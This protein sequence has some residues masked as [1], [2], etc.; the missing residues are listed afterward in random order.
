MKS[1]GDYAFYN[2][3]H[4]IEVKNLSTLG[5]TA[6]SSS[7]G[8]VGYYANRVYKEGASYLSTIDNGYIIYDDG[9]DKILVS[10]TGTETDLTLLSGI[11]QIYKYAFYNCSNLTSVTIGNKVTS[12]GSYAFYNCSKLPNVTIP[13]SVTSIG[14]YAFYNCSN[15][16]SLIFRDT[17][18]WYCTTNSS[19]WNN[20]TNGTRTDVTSSSSN[21]TYFKSTYCDYYW[22][23]L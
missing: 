8:Y 11:T 7:Y 21:A 9:T 13:S 4:L 15:L 17:S 10:Y 5:I 23:K 2:C 22:Y 1:I 16:T 12:I 14:S 19:N 18:T 20:K 6:G 3:Y